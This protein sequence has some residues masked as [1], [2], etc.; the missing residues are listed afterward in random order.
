V[1]WQQRLLLYQAVRANCGEATLV[2]LP[3][4]QHGQWNEFL[5]D[6]SVNAGAQVRR[7]D[8]GR[9]TQP[10]P[11]RLSWNYLIRFFDQN[12]RR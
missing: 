10:H 7:T 2:L 11:V 6:R 8:N 4:G 3:Q 5:T 9:E 1:P 12:M